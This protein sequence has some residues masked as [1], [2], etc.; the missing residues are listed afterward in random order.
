MGECIIG[1]KD[2]KHPGQVRNFNA[3]QSVRVTGSIPTFMVVAHN[4]PHRAHRAQR[5]Q[6]LF[7]DFNVSLHDLP[8]RLVEFSLFQQQA[9]RN[10]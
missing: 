4:R 2:L 1:V 8:F 6:Q 10:S 7:A 3:G 5:R 9:F